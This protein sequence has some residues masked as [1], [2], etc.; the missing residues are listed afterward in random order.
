MN[1]VSVVAPS[2]TTLLQVQ[3][4]VDRPVVDI[5]FKGIGFSYSTWMRPSGAGAC[6]AAG[7]DV[8]AGRL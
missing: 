6:A 4:T 1:K 3:G 7:R 5:C 2:L 8:S